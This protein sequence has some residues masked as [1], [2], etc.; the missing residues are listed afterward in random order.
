MRSRSDSRSAR[1]YARA[2]FE[3]CTPSDFEPREAALSQITEDLRSHAQLRAALDNPATPMTQ[4]EAAI[5]EYAKLI[6]PDDALFGNFL[7]VLLANKR[8]NP[9]NIQEISGLFSGMVDRFKKIFALDITTAMAISDAERGSL[10]E[11]IRARIPQG[12]ASWVAVDW[13]E[14]KALIGGIQVRAGDKVLDGSVK[15]ALERIERALL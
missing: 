13:H 5:R 8:L 6:R 4:R 7:A 12:Y 9:N 14:D 11:R 1:R 10:Q 3:L 2:L 15:G